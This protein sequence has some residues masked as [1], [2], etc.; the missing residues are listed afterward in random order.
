MASSGKGAAPL[1]L[2]DNLFEDLHDESPLAGPATPTGFAQALSPQDAEAPSAPPDP[3]IYV[4]RV[5]ARAKNASPTTGELEGCTNIIDLA[6][7]AGFKGDDDPLLFSLL[8]KV[9]LEASDPIKTFASLDQDDWKEDLKSWEYNGKPVASGDKAKARQL[10]HV[11]RVHAGLDEDTD[12][13]RPAQQ[14]DR[15]GDPKA[16]EGPGGRGQIDE[17]S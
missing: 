11:C 3:L 2:N 6:G 13:E 5:P 15:K 14:G 17:A 4:P 12:T 7:W 1:S 16:G 9:S 10:M 8:E